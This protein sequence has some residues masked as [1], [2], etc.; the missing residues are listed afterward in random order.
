MG[1]ATD[2]PAPVPPPP[3]V[4]DDVPKAKAAPEPFN[5]QK[6]EQENCSARMLRLHDKF[7]FLL[8]MFL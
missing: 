3:V 1:S 6:R 5:P 4:M 7:V 8:R 2:A